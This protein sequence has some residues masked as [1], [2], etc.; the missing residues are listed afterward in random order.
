MPLPQDPRARPHRCYT[1]SGEQRGPTH[2][3]HQVTNS[4]PE[5][6]AAVRRGACTRREW[7]PGP[8]TARRPSTREWLRGRDAGVREKGY[9]GGREGGFQGSGKGGRAGCED[10]GK[11]DAEPGSGRWRREPGMGR[12]RRG[13]SAAGRREGWRSR[14]PGSAQLGR[15]QGPPPGPLRPRIPE[16]RRGPGPGAAWAPG[17]HPPGPSAGRP[18]AARARKGSAP[19]APA[20]ARRRPQ[21][22]RRGRREDRVPGASWPRRP[23]R[24]AR[25]AGPGAERGAGRGAL[26]EEIGRAHV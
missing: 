25:G 26:G 11:G 16:P 15:A 5:G 6:A 12:G 17:G 1:D 9:G 18:N 22:W 2:E 13:M 19:G 4:H 20:A 23:P 8:R 7:A 21:R 14:A 10:L 3:A 24:G